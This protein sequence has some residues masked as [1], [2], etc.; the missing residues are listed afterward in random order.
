M[1]RAGRR[2]AVRTAR[3]WWLICAALVVCLGA[4]TVT[5]YA[6]ASHGYSAHE[7]DLNDGGIWATSDHDGLIGRASLPAGSLDTAFY[8][9]GGAQQDYQLDVIQDG[10]AVL[11]RDRGS[12]KLY[13]IDVATGAIESDKGIALSSDEQVQLDGGTLA[14]LDP[15]TGKLWA[16]RVDTVGGISGLGGIGGDAKPLAELGGSTAT[17]VGAAVAVGSDGSVFAV[18]ASG[19]VATIK[20]S[21]IGLSSVAYTQLD[22]ALQAPQITA[23]GHQYVVFDAK[24]GAVLLPGHRT[25]TIAGHGAEAQIQ[26][27]GPQARSVLIASGPDLYSIGLSNAAV[28]TLYSDGTGAAAAPVRLDDC[29]YAAWTGTPGV[30][31]RAC[32][33]GSAAPIALAGQKSIVQ[34]QLRVNRD[35]VVLN[36]VVN[37]AVWDLANGRRLDDWATV[38]PP[39]TVKPNTKSRKPNQDVGKVSAPPRAVDDTL[40]ARPGRST[41]LHVLDNDSDPGGNILSISAVTAPDNGA[42]K[43]SI[44]PD[45]QTVQIAMPAT[46]G[47][48]DFSY[49]VDDGKGLSASAKVT[50]QSRGPGQNDPPNLRPG[51]QPRVWNV[52]AGGA[53]SLPVLGDWRDFD[54]DPVL[55][56]S[57]S[58]H[59]GTISTTPDG[60]INYLAPLDAG[61]QTVN[62]TVSDGTA[63]QSTPV[64]VNV[65][66]VTSSQTTPAT[67][68]PDV[69]RGE[70]GQPIVIDPLDNDLPGADP[71]NPDARLQLAADVASPDGTQVVTDLKAGT[72]TLTASHPGTFLF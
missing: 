11:A 61:P 2:R 57:A 39:T 7:V 20:P 60:R 48:V 17:G 72:L 25:A 45:G 26:Q 4:G 34:P 69:A 63:T 49:T 27:P 50:V 38:K 41:V 42:A 37:G 52:A 33:S 16:V 67:T 43:L 22:A 32:G 58:A 47:D 24:T 8:P 71:S 15:A 54:G 53:L 21:H 44:S 31:V 13:P 10:G 29:A 6:L 28:S 18:S 23:V 66:P 59:A 46:A 62:Y 35:A 70:V 55:L 9:P 14:V 36:D 5:A 1:A 68:Q 19:K 56:V 30:A 3:H 64:T 12:G 65:L 51:F 40:G